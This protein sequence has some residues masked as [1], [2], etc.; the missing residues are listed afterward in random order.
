MTCYMHSGGRTC[1]L[2]IWNNISSLKF[3]LNLLS[4]SR[5]EG[6]CRVQRRYGGASEPSANL[7]LSFPSIVAASSCQPELQQNKILQRLHHEL[8]RR[9]QLSFLLS[10]HH[11]PKRYIYSPVSAS[12]A[13]SEGQIL[14]PDKDFSK[15]VDKQ[16]PEAE[17]LAQVRGT[18]APTLNV[19]L[20]LYCNRQM[21]RE[22]SRS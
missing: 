8:H 9:Y 12:P 3:L 15:E 7:N 4:R 17:Q 2:N 6:T 20:T 19:K 21:L 14:K 11:L 1:I 16:L 22:R 10:Y 18:S 5:D 13:M